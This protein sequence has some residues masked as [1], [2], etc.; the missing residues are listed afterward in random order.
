VKR[1]VLLI[2]SLILVA[3]CG[4]APSTT[5]APSATPVASIA[6]LSASTPAPTAA[7]TPSPTPRQAVLPGEPWLAF[8][9]DDGGG[10]YGVRLV[11]PDGTGTFFP[12]DTV[13]GTEQ[14]HPDWSPDG[15]RLVF[16][17]MGATARDL[18]VTDADGSNP[19]HI[20]VC[21]TCTQADEPA[22]SPDGKSIAFHRQS[23]VGA[24]SVSTLEIFD[25]A[26]RQS[27]VV[28]TAASD[29][30]FYAPR[31]SPDG[32]RIVSENIHDGGGQLVIVDLTAKTT[33]AVHITADGYWPANPDW[34]PDGTR[35][36]F[37][38]PLDPA[39]FDAESD[40]W[41]INPDGTGLKQITHFAAEHGI[42]IH[43]DYTPDGTRI[44]FVTGKAGADTSVMVTVAAD[45][46]D[47]QPATSNGYRPGLHPRFRPTP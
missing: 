22:W 5:I 4:A 35:I 43:P 8:Q 12:T 14:L 23:P 34:S 6:V 26:T 9:G 40:L 19:D 21:D 15:L 10:T 33:K 20:V 25:M 45:G 13:P 1:P 18:W 3:A 44:A 39:H 38:A 41:T 47:L 46:S 28:L 11:R 24:K 29:H 2:A 37:F 31:W 16:S 27:R 32:T 36:V 17:T 7:A 42:A 30:E